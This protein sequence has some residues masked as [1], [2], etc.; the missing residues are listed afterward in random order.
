VTDVSPETEIKASIGGSN[1]EILQEEFVAEIQIAKLEG[2]S[3]PGGRS[4]SFGESPVQGADI[5]FTTGIGNSAGPPV[6]QAE[7]KASDLE[8]VLFTDHD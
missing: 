2:S 8:T 4:R 7:C 5:H 3:L 6:R 1:R